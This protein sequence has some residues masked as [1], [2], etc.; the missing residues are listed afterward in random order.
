MDDL[1]SLVYGVPFLAEPAAS[2]GGAG[3]DNL[4]LESGD[5]FLLEDGGVLE[6][7]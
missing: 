1:L 2:G 5:N 6:L 4:L 7:E 3:V